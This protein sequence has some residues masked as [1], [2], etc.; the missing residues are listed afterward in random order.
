MHTFQPIRIRVFKPWYKKLYFS[1]NY[2]D[3]EMKW[4]AC[5]IFTDQTLWVP[6]LPYTTAVWT[7]SR[8][9]PAWKPEAYGR[10]LQLSVMW[11][12]DY[13]DQHPALRAWDFAAWQWKQMMNQAWP[14][15][16]VSRIASLFVELEQET[17]NNFQEF[18]FVFNKSVCTLKHGIK[19]PLHIWMLLFIYPLCLR[20][21]MY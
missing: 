14:L 19:G 10:S 15:V 18:P 1:S 6:S 13:V 9:H 2:L 7:R 5:V 4:P 21:L 3:F 12:Y 11:V 17:L 8:P 16:L 20:R